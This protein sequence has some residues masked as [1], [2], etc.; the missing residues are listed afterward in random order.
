MDNRTPLHVAGAEAV[1]PLA[2][3]DI[4]RKMRRNAQWLLSL[5]PD[6]IVACIR[7]PCGV[8]TRGVEPYGGWPSYY[9]YYVLALCN[10]HRA[11][12]GLDDSIAAAARERALYTVEAMLECQRAT[13]KT[14]PE[15]MLTPEDDAL[16]VGRM[17]LETDSVYSHTHIKAVMYDIHKDMVALLLAYRRFGM[18]E[19]LEGARRMAGRVRT[20]M[21]PLTQEERERTTNSRRVEPFFSEAGGIMDAFLMLY[22]HTH[23]P[24]DLETAGYFRRSWFDDMFLRDDDRLAYGMEHANS[25]SPYVEALVDQYRITGEQAALDA[26]RGFMRANR[27]G[28]ELPTGSVSG[29]SAFP[30]YQSELYNYPKRVYFH[31]M[32]TKSRHNVE[33]G[34]SCCAHNLNR[35]ERKLLEISP[36][37]VAAD[38]WERRF[39][40]AVL[41]Q[42][43]PDTGMFIYNLNLKNSAYK[44]WGTPE[45][46]FWCC[47]GTGAETYA[48]LTEG[49]FLEDAAHAYACLYMPCAYTHGPTGMRIVERTEYP[50]DGRIAFEFLDGGELTLCLRLP[51]WLQG[52]ARITLPDG[53]C[54]EHAE[55]GFVQLTR[56][57][58]AGDVVRLELPFALAAERMPD[59]LEY[60]S[61]TYGPNLLVA[62][63][64]QDAL[65]VGNQAE[66]LAS[67]A[68]NGEPCTF[69]VELQGA[70]AGH[71]VLRPIRLVKD[72]TYCGYIRLSEPPRREIADALAFGC[73]DSRE[74][75][76]LHG[77]RMQVGSHDG[78][79][80]LQTTLTFC[81]ERGEIEFEL[82]SHPGREMLLRLYLDGSTKMYIHPFS[83]HVVNPLFDLQVF[84][85]GEWH[86]FGTKSMEADFEG[87]I[88]YEDFV[89]PVKWT[90]DAD[91]L[92]LRLSARNFHEIPGV[93]EGLIDRLELYSVADA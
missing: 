48:S 82:A 10:L 58:R 14:C 84:A 86:T 56:T 81:S 43:N 19:A 79:A 40:N 23:D 24:R 85:Q 93:V 32:D 50:N 87:E 4:E 57:W 71:R 5:N 51:H 6:R 41:A 54:E 8:D 31:I 2:G 46:S 9:Y 16:L 26:A 11:F 92:R 34:E 37:A 62:C 60:V 78:H 69:C 39:V 36:D 91:R 76:G 73:A 52:P 42:Q 1:R 47:Y 30:D 35:V 28:H 80:T 7:I 83:G 53:T 77:V 15:G 64:P 88:Y 29:R 18:E 75:H 63:A 27:E 44:K 49:A 3:T 55:H 21:E 22:E 74:A 33:G 67:L 12:A 20:V 13:A 59:R 68:P 17:R 72:E 45:G 65:F 66:L 90:G 70:G 38:A 89:L 61:V 25:E